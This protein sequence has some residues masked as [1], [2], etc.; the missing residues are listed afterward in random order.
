MRTHF[1]SIM[2]T[3]LLMLPT[4]VNAQAIPYQNGRIIIS[5]DGNEHDED[6]WA[7]TPFSLALLASQG[8]QDQL[9]VYTFAD[10]IWGSNLK[11][12]PGHQKTDVGA[13]G[14]MQISALEG[15][16][17]F[18][19]SNSN[20]IEAVN[21]KN[22]AYNAIR[23]E[24]LAASAADPVYIVAA[25]PM[26][27]VGE[28]IDRAFNHANYTN[29]LNYVRL[30]SH[31]SWNDKHSDK[32]LDFEPNH[33]GWTWNEIS[34]SF[35]AHGLT[36]DHI[37]NQNDGP[38]YDGMRSDKSNFNWLN[39]SPYRNDP[40]YLPGSWDWLISRQ[41]AAKKGND[42]D[43]SDAGMVIY[44]LTG[45]E[46]T[47]PS[48]AKDLM[49]S[50]V[51]GGDIINDITDLTATASNCS[52][53]VLNWTDN[54]T[55]E[56]GFRIR[57]KIPGGTYINLQDVGPN[58]ETFTDNTTAESTEYIYMV[59]PLNNGSAAGTSN[60]PNETT[61]ACPGGNQDPVANAGADQS[62]T[63]TDDNGSETITLDGSGS[64]DSDGTIT[65]YVW[66]EGGSQIATGV[67]P[68]VSLSVGTHTITLTVTDNEGATGTDDVVVTVTAPS[69]G[70]V[71]LNHFS[72]GT[73]L[74]VSGGNV[75]TVS[76]TT[77]TDVA[78]WSLDDAGSG[79]FYI[80]NKSS[81]QKL[82]CTD[83]T[84]LAMVAASTNSDN[85]KWQWI[86]IDGTWF[87][88]ENKGFTKWLHVKPDG[89]SDLKCGPTTW[90]GNNTRWNSE[91]AGDPPV[92]YTITSSAGTN[93]S[94]SPTPS[95][96]VQ[97]GQ[98]QTFTI[99]PDA[100]YV[101]DDVLVDGGSVG[102]VSSYTFTNVTANGTI[103]ATFVAVPTYTITS[104]AGA[105]GSIS[106][107]PSATVQEG[108]NQ[109]FTITP[110][111]GYVIDDVLVDGGSVGAVS[112]YTFTNV[113]ANG[114]IS[115]SFAE[116][117]SQPITITPQ[118]IHDAYLQGTT[119]K[120]NT[121]IRVEAGNRV[122]YLMFDLSE[123]DGPI[124][125]AQLE[126]TCT[127]DNGNGNIDVNLGTSNNWTETT[128]SSSN[129]PGVGAL[130][131][132]KN[133]SYNIGTTYTWDLDVTALTGGGNLSLIVTHTSGND[134]A[135]GSKENAGNEQ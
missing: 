64:S 31:S 81:G 135:F 110:D 69:S 51:G 130:L 25:G 24:V 9:T 28:G 38:N 57:R 47:N 121:L 83:G 104:S 46:E 63:D 35:S 134:L 85:V 97:E 10:H 129:K 5:S 133:V 99:T 80:V 107:T 54:S 120:N 40:A 53:V 119:R 12:P 66:T 56:D 128:L 124:T 20:F 87:R 82:Q 8:L 39:T 98:N 45:I 55:G 78:Q 36:M 59:R 17:Q 7:G 91:P 15:K 33:S 95:A 94:I 58:I 92:T 77:T 75:S 29:Q 1:F 100:G 117:T 19:F 112:S 122:G 43:P 108:Q 102:A 41:E 123:V 52:T 127:D 106:P 116:E 103:S 113:T 76:G 115:A 72:S 114:T 34:N 16:T 93:G 27:V 70:Y 90:T 30:I 22:Q 67:A 48:D 4:L 88:L 86:S 61:P 71:F 21:N 109:T 111:A 13:L 68:N 79:Y 49:E 60:T 42:Y 6:D 32:P 89:V 23:D 96:T 3:A 132:S 101:I 131:A 74:A 73:R 14:E 37:V 125:A 2:L 26:Q 65:S 62:V 11:Y 105:N 50:P 44:L 126:L 18:G 84:V 118:P